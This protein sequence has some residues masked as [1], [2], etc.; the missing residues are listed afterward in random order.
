MLFKS[1]VE[2]LE[3]TLLRLL[4]ARMHLPDKDV[5]NYR[6]LIKGYEGEQK[7]DDG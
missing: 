5:S 2:L 3:I 6:T 1:R 4:N 7:S